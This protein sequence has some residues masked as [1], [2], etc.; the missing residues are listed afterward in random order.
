MCGVL[1]IEALLIVVLDMVCNV[2]V[3][4]LIFLLCGYK[5]D[6]VIIL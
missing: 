6:V 3:G 1:C 2:W 4:Y 5:L